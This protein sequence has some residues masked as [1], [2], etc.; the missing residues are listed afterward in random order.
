[1]NKPAKQPGEGQQPMRYHNRVNHPSTVV[2]NHRCE[3]NRT[4]RETEATSSHPVAPAKDTQDAMALIP[5]WFPLLL[6]VVR[7]SG[8]LARPCRPSP[9]PVRSRLNDV[10]CNTGH[11]WV[12]GVTE[13][14]P[15]ADLS[16]C[17][18]DLRF[19]VGRETEAY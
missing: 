19:G 10:A 7:M 17:A 13:E 3:T 12:N 16:V 6:L 5:L 8:W 11:W 18:C 15:V 14:G 9:L 4:T 2:Q 1:M